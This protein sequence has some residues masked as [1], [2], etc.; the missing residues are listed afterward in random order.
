M[1]DVDQEK[2]LRLVKE[3]GLWWLYE[4]WSAKPKGKDVTSPHIDS[5]RS[6]A[7]PRLLLEIPSPTCPDSQSVLRRQGVEL[8]L[9]SFLANVAHYLFLYSPAEL[10]C[11]LPASEDL[12]DEDLSSEMCLIL[13]VGAQYG[14]FRADPVPAEWYAK[15]QVQLRIEY[16]DDLSLMRTLTMICLLK[17]GDDIELASQ[18]L[19]IGFSP[20]RWQLLL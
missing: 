8:L 11:M 4:A 9:D 5:S 10:R 6:P 16:Q 12:S 17:I 15:A 3:G 18:I 19:G 13:A 20:T 7:T 14:N 2:S 1:Q